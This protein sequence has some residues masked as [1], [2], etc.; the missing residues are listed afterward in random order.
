MHTELPGEE[1]DLSALTYPQFVEFFFARPVVGENERYDLFRSGID[2]FVPSHPAIVVDHLRRICCELSEPTNACSREQI[3]QGWWA[4]FGA[5]IECQRFLFAPSVDPSLRTACIES[6]YLPFRDVVAKS[7]LGKR[8]SFYWM[9]WDLVLET[10]GNE[11][12]EVY[13]E[14]SSDAKQML[15]SIYETLVK[16]L[17]LDHLACQWSALHGLGHSPHPKVRE[18]VQRYLDLHRVDLSEEDTEWVER[19]SEGRIA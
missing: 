8:D 3:D 18:T 9:W 12:T 19:C 6:M 10:F 5:G 16:I 17:A 2:S 4:V 7:T 11:T 13:E 15:E 1:F 14:L